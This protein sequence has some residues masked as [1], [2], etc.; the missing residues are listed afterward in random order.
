M[1]PA[2]QAYIT[3]LLVNQKSYVHKIYANPEHVHILCELPRTMIISELVQKT[4]TSS[5]AWMKSNGQ[6]SFEWQNGYGVFSTSQSKLDIVKEYIQRQPE[7]HAKLSFED[8]FRLFLKE[9]QINFDEKY[10]WD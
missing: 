6:K 3:K 8:E 10:V 4:K 1:R 5:S 2:L 7:H 9:Y